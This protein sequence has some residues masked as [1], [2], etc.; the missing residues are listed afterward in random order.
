MPEQPAPTPRPAVPEVVHGPVAASADPADAPAPAPPS[1]RAQVLITGPAAR[2]SSE[3]EMT[4]PEG[5]AADPKAGPGAYWI[6]LLVFAIAFLVVMPLIIA[7]VFGWAEAAVALAIGGVAAVLATM[8][9]V[10]V[11]RGKD[12]EEVLEQRD[13]QSRTLD[14]EGGP[15]PRQRR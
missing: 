2:A 4:S 1:H 3:V 11:E 8:A 5:R 7:M 9:W 14:P 13:H 15:L 10:L 6:I 12:R